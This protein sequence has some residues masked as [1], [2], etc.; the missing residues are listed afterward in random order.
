[1][2][3]HTHYEGL[4]YTKLRLSKEMIEFKD[5]YNRLVPILR[6]G[7]CTC[8]K[9]PHSDYCPLSPKNEEPSVAT[10]DKIVEHAICDK[11]GKEHEEPIDEKLSNRRRKE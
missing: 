2:S 4:G 1:M 3:E 6:M 9:I 10:K 7:A 8:R 5:E 11:C